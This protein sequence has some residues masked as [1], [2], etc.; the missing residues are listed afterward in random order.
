MSELSYTHKYRS[1]ILCVTGQLFAISFYSGFV[2]LSEK[3]VHECIL[4]NSLLLVYLCC[5]LLWSNPIKYGIVHRIDGVIA[6]VSIVYFIT[7]TITYK[8]MDC[9]TKYSYYMVVFGIITNAYLSNY[10]SNKEWCSNAHIYY[11]ALLH[12]FCFIGTF[13]AFLP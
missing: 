11:H 13:Y 2:T 10:Y 1:F 5:N 4:G 6:K 3:N 7:Y 12:I 8:K 9:I